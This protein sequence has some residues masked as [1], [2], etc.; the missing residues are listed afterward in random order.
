VPEITVR[1]ETTSNANEAAE[2]VALWNLQ[3]KA[4]KALKQRSVL[5]CGISAAIA[6]AYLI[7]R[8]GHN[9][10]FA[11]PVAI[12][13]AVAVGGAYALS[14]DAFLRRRVRRYLRETL[15]TAP[16]TFIAEHRDTGLWFRQHDL[17]ALWNWSALRETKETE[18]GVE[19]WFDTGIVVARKR[20]FATP[21]DQHRFAERARE[22]A[23]RS[24]I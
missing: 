8:D 16:Y 17:E 2:V 23:A 11:V 24:R 22:L 14:Y 10:A 3:S 12:I 19:M 5:S 20:A 9:W 4:G 6:A 21:E 13:A 7:F 18:R 15:G 1:I